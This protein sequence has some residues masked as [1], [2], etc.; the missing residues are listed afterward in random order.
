MTSWPDVELLLPDARTVDGD[1]DLLDLYDAPGPHVRAGM[2]MSLDGGVAHGGTSRPLQRPGDGLVFAALRA[3]SDTVMVGAGTARIEGYGP[4]R[5]SDLDREW[6]QRHGRLP[7]VPLVVVSRSLDIPIDAAWLSGQAVVVTCAA[8]PSDRRAALQERVDVVVAGHSQVDLP[9]ALAQ[10]S[11]RGLV[12]V[13]CEGGPSLLGDLVRQELVSEFY[14]TVAPVLVGESQ[15]MVDKALAAPI[16]L[17]LTHLL[18]EG[19]TLLGR[20]R[21]R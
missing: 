19:S 21:V 15:G 18:R 14:A 13:L 7:D 4:V 16:D 11:D 9:Q 2:L 1:D 12:R 20:W 3:V 6:R 17:E 8:A 10:L 5:L